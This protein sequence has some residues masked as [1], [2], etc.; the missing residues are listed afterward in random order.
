[1]K[2]STKVFGKRSKN[3]INEKDSDPHSAN[4]NSDSNSIQDHPQD[5]DLGSDK[6][7]HES[8]RITK[9]KYNLNT[10]SGQLPN[11]QS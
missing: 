1:M 3:Q 10:I 7:E 4:K 9:G 5:E 2:Q 11:K 6:V 8:S